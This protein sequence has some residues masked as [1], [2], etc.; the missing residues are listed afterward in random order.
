MSYRLIHVLLEKFAGVTIDSSDSIEE[1]VRTRRARSM[2]SLHIE[3]SKLGS[4]TKRLE[5]VDPLG[6]P[7]GSLP[8]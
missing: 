7:I 5:R 1:Y 8:E 6:P 3:A 4:I 2:S